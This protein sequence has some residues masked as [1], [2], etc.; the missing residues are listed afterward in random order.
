MTPSKTILEKERLAMKVL[1]ALSKIDQWGLR[2]LI[3]TN[4]TFAGIVYNI[5]SVPAGDTPF[6]R[7]NVLYI[8]DANGKKVR[9]YAEFFDGSTLNPCIIFNCVDAP[10]MVTMRKSP[11]LDDD[12]DNMEWVIVGARA[13]NIADMK[14]DL[15]AK[16][17]IIDDLSYI[18]E[19]K[20]QTI[21]AQKREIT[22]LRERV[23]I[24]EKENDELSRKVVDYETML[25]QISILVEKHM[26]GELEAT[27]AMQEILARA[28]RA[29]K[30][31]VMG[32]RERLVEVL[33]R[34][35]EISEALQII[36]GGGNG[37]KA[38]D[39]E[40]KLADIVERKLREL[41]PQIVEQLK[42]AQ[43]ELKVE[44]EKSEEKPLV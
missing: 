17:Q 41:V 36:Y 4:N 26:A 28:D 20:Q 40:R 21:N 31:E 22:A 1:K 37:V 35:K 30:W 25:S 12:M 33:R 32:L 23:K 13:E 11:T 6:G 5:E 15:V 27:T 29:G 38:E 34:E 3:R 16:Q 43:P 42:R 19:Q 2:I 24:Y 10:I 39:L 7:R 18:L 44:K 9:E 8:L 14:A